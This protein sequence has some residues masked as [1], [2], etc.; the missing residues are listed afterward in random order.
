[1]FIVTITAV[2]GEQ[3]AFADSLSLFHTTFVDSFSV[4]S[5]ETNPEGLAFSS[6][7]T[8]MFVVGDDGDDVNEYTLST[9]FDVSTGVFVDSF[10]VAAQDTFPSG[11][12]FSSDGAK[13]FV[14]GIAGDD[15]NEYS[16]TSILPCSPPSSGIWIITESCEISSDIIAPA[17][18]MIQNSAVVTI[19]SEGS[20]TVPAGENLIVVGGSGLKLI[21]GSA[22]NILS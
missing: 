20:L 16:I 19:N 6:D 7:G 12:A 14:V 17:S 3:I 4:A 9:P 11:L 22:L 1:M 15:I 8:K 2:S 18:V 21:Q 5:Q 13:M 10:S